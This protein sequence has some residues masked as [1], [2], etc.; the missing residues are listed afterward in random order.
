MNTED[1]YKLSGIMSA[2]DWPSFKKELAYRYG[3][4]TSQ[5]YRT[6]HEQYNSN[7][8]QADFDYAFNE[9][10]FRDGPV[11]HT[12]DTCYYGCSITMGDGVPQADR[13][14]SCMDQQ[15]TWT[16]NNF[17]IAGTGIE[18][19]LYMFVQTARLVQMKRAV[20]FLP[21]ASRYTVAVPQDSDN[22]TYN[23]IYANNFEQLKHTELRRT[24]EL[25][26]RLPDT[27]SID[28]ART[29][30]NLIRCIAELHHIQVILGSWS[31]TVFDLLQHTP[32]HRPVQLDRA[33]R[34]ALHPGTV[35][36]GRV[37]DQFGQL[38]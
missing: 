10:G 31:T 9:Y 8:T 5:H 20:F 37:A 4:A 12:V 2:H 30:I 24:A 26:Y 21:D 35:Y 27:Y 17:A 23:N 29:A 28:R 14:T 34:D 36:H 38:L 32:D 1:F 25:L 22:I 33:G 16:S 11:Q 7:W 6:A 3:I 18:E 13:W 19:C 15:H